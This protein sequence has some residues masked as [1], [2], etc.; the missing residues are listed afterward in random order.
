[1]IPSIE[2]IVEDLANGSI[3]TAQAVTWLHQ[4]AEGAANELRNAFAMSAMQGLL[5]GTYG[6]RDL[7]YIPKNGLSMMGNQARLAYQMADAM[8]AE[9][10]AV[11]F[12]SEQ[13]G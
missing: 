1:M 11:R 7:D 10:R 6:W 8:L 13:E 2:Q 5:S 9:G 12:I 3:G 4:H